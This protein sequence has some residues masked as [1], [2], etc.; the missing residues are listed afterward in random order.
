MVLSSCGTSRKKWHV[1]ERAVLLFKHESQMPADGALFR[2]PL[3][4]LVHE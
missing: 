3:P 1:I 2:D 4:D